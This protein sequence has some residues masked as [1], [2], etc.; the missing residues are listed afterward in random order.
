MF[1]EYDIVELVTD[2]DTTLRAGTRGTIVMAYPGNP[3]E[4]EVEFVNAN[5]DTLCLRTVKEDQ[6]RKVKTT[7]V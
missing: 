3:P 6:I 2:L 4:F 5:G 1:E 7:D